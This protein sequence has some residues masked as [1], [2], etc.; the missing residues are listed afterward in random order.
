MQL[1]ATARPDAGIAMPM[2]LHGARMALYDGA[3]RGPYDGRRR[4]VCRQQMAFRSNNF[5]MT[6]ASDRNEAAQGIEAAC[7]SPTAIAFCVFRGGGA[8]RAIWPKISFRSLD[9]PERTPDGTDRRSALCNARGEQSDARPR[10]FGAP[11]ARCAMPRGLRLRRRSTS[12][13]TALIS[14]EQLA[15]RTGDHGDRRPLRAHLPP[16]PRRWRRPARY[17]ARGRRQPE[18]RRGR[19]AQGLCRH[20]QAEELKQFDA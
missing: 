9:A 20:R 4:G 11:G 12:A 19:L 3:I 14:R 5:P 2:R 1:A 8:A 7:C 18:H 15:R 13:E 16:V 17:R 10:S 6:E